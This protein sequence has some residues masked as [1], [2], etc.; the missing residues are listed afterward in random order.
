ME[1]IEKE[2]VPEVSET[3]DNDCP[4]GYVCEN[5]GDCEFKGGCSFGR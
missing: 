5:G 2:P 4:F 1:E 3:P